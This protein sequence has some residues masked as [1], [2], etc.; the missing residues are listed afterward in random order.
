MR[1]PGRQR[2]D[3][4]YTLRT[5]QTLSLLGSRY[6][7]I[8]TCTSRRGRHD[9]GVKQQQHWF[10]GGGRGVEGYLSLRVDWGPGLLGFKLL[11]DI[12]R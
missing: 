1:E 8:Y 10:R 6:M 4:T 2:G 7:H 3:D 9:L 11:R 5:S 12:R